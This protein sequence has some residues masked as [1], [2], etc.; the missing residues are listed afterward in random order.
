M[1]ALLSVFQIAVFTVG[2]RT[3]TGGRI[4]QLKHSCRNI[5]AAITINVKDN[6]VDV[7]TIISVISAPVISVYEDDKFALVNQSTH[8]KLTEKSNQNFVERT[9][10]IEG[11]TLPVM[12]VSSDKVDFSVISQ[13]PTVKIAESRDDTL[14]ER[15]FGS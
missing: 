3:S 7:D 12:D 5:G 4:S 13:S 2:S 11:E 15:I 6:L 14:V 8:T 1:I 10:Y 9:F